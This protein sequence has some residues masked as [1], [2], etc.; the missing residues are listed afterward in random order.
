MQENLGNINGFKVGEYFVTF[1]PGDFIKEDSEG[2]MYAVVD[3]Y[4]IEKN[5]KATKIKQESLSK[6]LEEQI[7]DELNKFLLAA[8]E[9]NRTSINS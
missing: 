9:N 2:K 7:N 5:N 1:P 4:K 8:L 3:I 6:E